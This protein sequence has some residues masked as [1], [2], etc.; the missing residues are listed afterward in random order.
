MTENDVN[1]LII[2]FNN[3]ERTEKKHLIHT[4]SCEPNLK[5]VFF[6]FIFIFLFSPF[7]PNKMKMK[8]ETNRKPK[9]K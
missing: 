6:I 2:K 1:T 5:H 3:N 8:Y 7:Q 9:K 4:L